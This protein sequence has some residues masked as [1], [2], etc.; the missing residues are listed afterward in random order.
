METAGRD[1]SGKIGKRGQD[2]I[3]SI[4]ANK[5]QAAEMVT[6]Y[7]S[8]ATAL[9]KQAGNVE[10]TLT[11]AE[12]TAEINKAE[13]EIAN[14]KKAADEIE[15]ADKAG[16]VKKYKE[17]NAEFQN[18]VKLRDTV[19]MRDI[20]Q[21]GNVVARK[22][23]VTNA[24]FK[25]MRAFA[26]ANKTIDKASKVARLSMR[27]GKIRDWLFMSTMKN[28]GALGKATSKIGFWVGALNTVKDFYDFSETST[29]E[30][31][32]NIEF[33]PL[34][35]LSA[36]NLE[37]QEN[38][39]S[40]GMWFMFAGDSVNPADDDAAF[41][42]A[43]DFAEKFYQDMED[44]QAQLMG[45]NTER[46]ARA[47][48]IANKRAAAANAGTEREQTAEQDAEANKTKFG[49]NNA[50]RIAKA[51]LT[52]AGGLQFLQGGGMPAGFCDVDIFVVRP[53]IR[54]PDT[55]GGGELFYLIMN[56]EPWRIRSE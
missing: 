29:G 32:N 25:A 4:E 49:L 5:K 19:K 45:D 53:I 12:K 39:V 50:G 14:L 40:H 42:Q 2:A 28:I 18:L 44:V 22:I 17:A 36:D 34:L 1:K 41:L 16:N 8:E 23:R 56:D 13:E 15:K 48:N 51:A 6:K 11:Q 47:K 3:K 35:L 30:F 10:K 55:D 7:Q 54:N 52:P 20:P 24:A 21:K 37:G 9:E 46:E 33:K 26:N 31:T 38:V 27:S 43:M